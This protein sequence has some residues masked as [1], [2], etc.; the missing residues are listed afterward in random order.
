MNN[1]DQTWNHLQA[2]RSKAPLVHNITNY[3]VMNNTANALL[4]LGASPVMAHA[5]EEVADMVKIANSLVVNIGTLSPHWVEAMALAMEAAKKKGIPIIVDPVGAGATP[6][7]TRTLHELM[8]ENYP[9]IIRGNAS[10]IIAL[11]SADAQTKGVDS[12]EASDSARE[13]A[14]YLSDKYDSVVV[15][16]G[17]VDYIIEGTNVIQVRNGNELMAKVTG[18]GC[19]ASSLVGAFAGAVEDNAEAAASAMR[20]MGI[21]GE[22][23]AEA[24]KGPG[25]LQLHFIDALYNID[26]S[27]IETK[28]SD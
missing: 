22:L 19:T 3:V 27:D 2:V 28:L 26:K 20:I 4:A 7:R 16:S 25:T 23:A 17:K 24:A 6:Y 9:D 18:M 11:H 13:A 5:K 10:E 12:T 8:D 1:I 15:V 14:F 21:A